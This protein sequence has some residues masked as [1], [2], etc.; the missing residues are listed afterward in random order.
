MADLKAKAAEESARITAQAQVQ[1]EA[2]R[3]AAVN[4]L[5]IEVGTL[6]TSLAGKIVGEA[7]DDDA[8]SNRVVERFLTDLENQANAGVTK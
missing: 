6:A 8:R 1:I 2:E 3:V 5:R 4:S 7:L